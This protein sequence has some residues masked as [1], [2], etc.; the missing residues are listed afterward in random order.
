MGRYNGPLCAM[1]AGVAAQSL[2][3]RRNRQNY[4]NCAAPHYRNSLGGKTTDQ[5]ARWLYAPMRHAVL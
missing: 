2:P 1:P 4:R 3:T 5:R